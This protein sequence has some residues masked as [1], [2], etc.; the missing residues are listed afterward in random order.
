MALMK[1]VNLPSP[2][3]LP[4][5]VNQISSSSSNSIAPITPTTSPFMIQ[6][7]VGLEAVARSKSEVGSDGED[8]TTPGTRMLKN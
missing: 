1:T 7:Q 3:R 5:M 6:Y 8:R 4:S 2:P